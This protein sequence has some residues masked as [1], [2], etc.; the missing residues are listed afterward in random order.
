MAEEHVTHVTSND[1]GGV[2]G[3]KNTVC[4]PNIV[5]VMATSQLSIDTLPQRVHSQDDD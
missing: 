1:T 4:A 5:S 2:F 3:E